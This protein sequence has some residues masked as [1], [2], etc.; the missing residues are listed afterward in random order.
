MVLLCPSSWSSLVSSPSGYGR[1]CSVRGQR[2]RQP[3]RWVEP[4][5]NKAQTF[6][7]ILSIIFVS[8]SLPTFGSLLEQ[9][10]NQSIRSLRPYR[11]RLVCCAVD[12]F[13]SNTA[14]AISQ[15]LSVSLCLCGAFPECSVS[16]PG[17]LRGPC[18]GSDQHH[19]PG[20]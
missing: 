8:A 2:P 20:V 10:A 14:A 9:S 5:L 12:I 3:E 19:W 13:H 7:C 16:H 1:V 6:Y 11:A 18:T 4:L 17:V 15:S